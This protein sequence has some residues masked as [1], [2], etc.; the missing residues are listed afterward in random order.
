MGIWLMYRKYLGETIIVVPVCSMWLSLYE[1]IEDASYTAWLAVKSAE[2]AKEHAE[3]AGF[4]CKE[5]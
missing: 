5:E 3:F 1:K 2:E 4:I